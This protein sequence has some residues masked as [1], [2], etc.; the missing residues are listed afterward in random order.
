[1]AKADP[2]LRFKCLDLAMRSST[3]KLETALV[4]AER[5][6]AF[7]EGQDTDT[8]PAPEPAPKAEPEVKKLPGQPAKAP[9]TAGKTAAKDSP[10]S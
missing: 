8:K 10:S 4:T 3:F 5:F 6:V 2:E 9:K 1:M 7:V